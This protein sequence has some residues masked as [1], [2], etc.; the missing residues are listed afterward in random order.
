MTII[1][2]LIGFGLFVFGYYLL[3]KHCDILFI[4][5]DKQPHITDLI[6]ALVGFFLMPTGG[7][8]AATANNIAKHLNI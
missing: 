8:I 1:I 6:L 7:M 3:E 5:G 4:P 2:F